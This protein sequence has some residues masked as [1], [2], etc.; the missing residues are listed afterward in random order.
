MERFKKKTEKQQ[1][2]YDELQKQRLQALEQAKDIIV[3]EDPSLPKPIRI[4]I[5]RKD[6][7][8]GDK[9]KKGTY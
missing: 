3:K 7:E 5:N 8:P 4:T 6:I 9:D 2:I 1:A